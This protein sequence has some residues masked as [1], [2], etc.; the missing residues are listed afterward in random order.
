M[1]S[2]NQAV[3][4]TN[5]LSLFDMMGF[6]SNEVPEE[7]A[8]TVKKARSKRRSAKPK[9]SVQQQMELMLDVLESPDAICDVPSGWTDD[10][11]SGLREF[12]LNRHL[13]FILD[14]R[15]G[16]AMAS[17][18]WDWVLSE[19]IHPFSFRVCVEDAALQ[20]GLSFGD[21][22]CVDRDEIREVFYALA[23]RAGAPLNF[24][25]L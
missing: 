8:N 7:I 6:G 1:T 15:S 18:A 14:G 12:M 19:E 9:L 4:E 23:K 24:C 3:L 13:N 17:E 22:I 21:W 25:L 16:K 11:I 20:L 5:Q 10:D 2:Q